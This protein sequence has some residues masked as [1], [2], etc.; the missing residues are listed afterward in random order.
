MI[1]SDELELRK[2]VAPEIV[3]GQGA[4]YMAG[5]YAKN[6][7]ARKVLLVSD[8]GVIAAGWTQQVMDSLESENIAHVLFSE[9]T[10]NPRAEEVMA[11]AEIYKQE[12]C[13]VILV[14]GGGSPIDCAKGIG[15]VSSNHKHILEFLGIDNVPIPGPPLICIPTTAGSAA[16]ISQFAIITDLQQKI[17]TTIISKAMVPDLSLIDPETTTTMDAELTGYTGLDVMVHAME[18]YVSTA[19]SPLTDVHALEAIR[20]VYEYLPQVV[21]QPDNLEIRNKMMLASTHAGLAFSNASLGTIHA[22]SHS[23]SGL[24]D[25]PHGLVNALL[26]ETVVSFN[27]Q[28][29]AE[30]YQTIGRALGLNLQG[31][32]AAEIKCLLL[33]ELK[34]LRIKGGVDRTLSDYGVCIANI[35]EL[36]RKAMEDCCMV[37][38]P[39]ETTQRDI[40]VL[41]EQLL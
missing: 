5:R 34:Q 11:G 19:H 4:R 3:F 35:P 24:F 8:P 27:F 30:R 14:V 31:K 32:D 38:N 20:L 41:Y 28:A 26:L 40:E 23:L 16:D 21:E 12:K 25:L 36:A 6:F 7:G 10:S 17:K 2:F 15:I 37:T 39:R 18:A 22:M 33:S 13:D 29:V 1:S 9:V